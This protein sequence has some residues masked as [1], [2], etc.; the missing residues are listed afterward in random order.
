[1]DTKARKRYKS[2]FPS[3]PALSQPSTP[4]CRERFTVG[5]MPSKVSL[6]IYLHIELNLQHDPG[7]TQSNP[8]FHHRVSSSFEKHQGR[9]PTQKICLLSFSSL[10]SYSKFITFLQSQTR[11]MHE[12]TKYPCSVSKSGGT[13]LS[14]R[15]PQQLQP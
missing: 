2:P 13:T 15:K 6:K 11:K 3:F 4:K 1:M 9:V 10:L 14:Q 8:I 12:L 5:G 7:Q